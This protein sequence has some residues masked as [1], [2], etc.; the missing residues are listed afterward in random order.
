MNIPSSQSVSSHNSQGFKNETL[1]ILKRHSIKIP[2]K[3]I[4]SKTKM[5]SLKLNK[6][7]SHSK[8]ESKDKK[9]DVSSSHKSIHDS[10][11]Q[12]SLI[13]PP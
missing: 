9:K 3:K 5:K 7:K 8:F 13:K 6:S 12:L 10:S 4:G 11:S 2:K 1:E